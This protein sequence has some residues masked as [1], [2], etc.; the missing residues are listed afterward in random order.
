MSRDSSVDERLLASLG[1]LPF[2][3]SSRVWS[4]FWLP[5]IDKN[6]FKHDILNWMANLMIHD[7]E[8]NDGIVM[9]LIF[10]IILW[11]ITQCLVYRCMPMT[12][13]HVEAED[14]YCLSLLIRDKGI[15]F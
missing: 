3:Q 4:Y 10:A 9:A 13:Y 7:D 12:R 5:L 1:E 8:D 6:R 15:S 14:R 11:L 2:I